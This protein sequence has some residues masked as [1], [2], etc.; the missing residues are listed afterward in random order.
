M[1]EHMTDQR[2]GRCHCGAVHYRISGAVKGVVNCHCNSCRQRNGA[3]YSTYCVVAEDDFRVV[4]GAE[5]L[6]AYQVTEISTKHF[7]AAC[8]TPVYN[9]NG[10]Y[11]GLRIAYYGTLT[12]H[13]GLAPAVN[14]YCESKLAW[15]DGIKGLKSFERSLAG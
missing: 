12:D 11:P 1:T 4:Q 7:C 15:V 9:T 10:R 6:A 3:A 8:G 14:I 5:Q 2:S 13:A